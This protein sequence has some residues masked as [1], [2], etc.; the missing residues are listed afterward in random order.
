MQVASSTIPAKETHI[1]GIKVWVYADSETAYVTTFSIYSGM[2][3]EIGQGYGMSSGNDPVAGL[4]K[5]LQG[6][7]LY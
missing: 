6:V 7:L 3:K 2:G 4:W 1:W 5:A